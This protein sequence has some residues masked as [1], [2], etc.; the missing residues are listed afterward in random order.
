MDCPTISSRADAEALQPGEIGFY[1]M[2]LV[3]SVTASR[4]DQ[5]SGY[6]PMP[7]C[8]EVVAAQSPSPSSLAATIKMLQPDMVHS[9]ELQHGAYLCLEARRRMGASFPIWVASNWGSDLFLY[10]R[11]PTHVPMLREVMRNLDGLHSECARDNRIATDLGFRGVRFPNVPAS[12]GSDPSLFDETADLEPP[13]KRKMLLIKGYHGWAGRGQHLILAVHRIAPMLKGFRVRVT[14]SDANMVDLV[15]AVA[16]EDGLDIAVDQYYPDHKAALK[17]LTQAR[18]VV[19]CGIS[20]GIST[21]LLESMMV[22]AFPIQ[23]DSACACEW[24]ESGVGGFVVP[25]HDNGAFAEA[26]VKAISDD[27]LVDHAAVI[28]REVV[29]KRWNTNAVGPVILRAYQDVFSA[30]RAQLA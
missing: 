21:T 19:G 28:N 9:L 14:H 30:A 10:H 18:A 16:E 26:I 29:M 11:L 25:S 7:S 24:I 22:G 8:V 20:D 4:E 12:G 17:R 3:Q 23:A 2:S 27:H 6:L 1:N 13:S 5:A 15:K